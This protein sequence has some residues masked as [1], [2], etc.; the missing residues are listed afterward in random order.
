MTPCD[1][2]VDKYLELVLHVQETKKQNTL[3]SIP[4]IN[5]RWGRC[6]ADLDAGLWICG[7]NTSKDL[8]NPTDVSSG[9]EAG[10]RHSGV[11]SHISRAE[12]AEVAKNLLGVKA[13]GVDEI[14]L[15]FLE[16]AVMADMTLQ[17]HMVIGGGAAGL[18]DGSGGPSF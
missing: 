4:V 3:K 10:P 15:G 13:L 6:A 8:L 9:E 12:V 14:R 5:V 1:P 11:G 16:V 17:H 7:K 2:D 18:A